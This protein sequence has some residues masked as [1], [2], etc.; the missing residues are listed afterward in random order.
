MVVISKKKEKKN[1]NNEK[2]KKKQQL[3]GRGHKR[4]QS[5]ILESKGYS[6]IRISG[7]LHQNNDLEARKCSK[8]CKREPP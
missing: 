7:R 5:K 8:T 4:I 3:D 2:S 6:K 1:Q